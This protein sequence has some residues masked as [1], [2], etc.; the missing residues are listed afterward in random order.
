[1]NP[2]LPGFDVH[3]ACPLPWPSLAA[4]WERQ[5]EDQGNSEWLLMKWWGAPGGG[6]EHLPMVVQR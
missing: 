1:M 4:T 5:N 3:S 2:A 6:S